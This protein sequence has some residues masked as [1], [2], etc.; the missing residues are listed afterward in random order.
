MHTWIAEIQ[1]GLGLGLPSSILLVIALG[2]QESTWIAMISMIRSTP[3]TGDMYSDNNIQIV[4]EFCTKSTF[5]WFVQWLWMIQI[6]YNE[7]H[8]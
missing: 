7:S 3:L 5:S 2:S 1:S 6:N 4:D 8:P